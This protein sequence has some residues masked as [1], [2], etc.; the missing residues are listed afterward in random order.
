[1]PRKW[2]IRDTE[3]EGYFVVTSMW[4]AWDKQDRP[5]WEEYEEVVEEEK[6]VEWVRKEIL[7]EK[8]NE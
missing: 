5:F 6:L 7:Q 2:I 8:E 1:M 4:K 3:S